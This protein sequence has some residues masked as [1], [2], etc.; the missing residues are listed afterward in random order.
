MVRYNLD[1]KKFLKCAGNAKTYECHGC[2]NYN[3]I[4]SL[5]TNVLKFHW[6][7]ADG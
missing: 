2:G 7:C 1:C 5:L 6:K 3:A 4:P